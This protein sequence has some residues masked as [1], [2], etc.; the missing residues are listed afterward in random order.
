M[1]SRATRMPVRS[2][3]LALP[4]GPVA[5]Q[6][7]GGKTRFTG[8]PGPGATPPCQFPGSDHFWLTPA[9]ESAPDQVNVFVA[10]AVAVAA[11]AAGAIGTMAAAVAIASAPATRSQDR[12]DMSYRL[13]WGAQCSLAACH[14]STCAA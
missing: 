8:R 6:C 5:V 4:H 1:V 7:N 14:R 11:P 3:R 13:R 10:V 9:A 2:L 12:T